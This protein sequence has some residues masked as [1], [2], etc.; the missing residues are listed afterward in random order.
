MFLYIFF[1]S[2]DDFGKILSENR[3]ISKFFVVISV[4]YT[5]KQIHII[6]IE[7]KY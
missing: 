7:V 1:Y 5:K 3:K 2:Q 4:F 6:R